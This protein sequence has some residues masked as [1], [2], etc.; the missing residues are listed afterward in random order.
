MVIE[1]LMDN[2]EKAYKG[3]QF[4]FLLWTPYDDDYYPQLAILYGCP[5]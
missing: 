5:C 1:A 2:P 3:E 4:A